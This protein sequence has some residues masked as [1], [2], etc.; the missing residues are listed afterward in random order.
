MLH[1]SGNTVDILIASRDYTFVIH[2]NGNNDADGGDGR[3]GG[4]Q[5]MPAAEV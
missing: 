1:D 4:R 2:D 3:R 5:I